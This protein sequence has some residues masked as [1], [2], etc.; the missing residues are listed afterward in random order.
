MLDDDI[1]GG[2]PDRASRALF[3]HSGARP[4]RAPPSRELA[5]AIASS[6]KVH[7]SSRADRLG[8]GGDHLPFYNPLPAGALHTFTEPL[9]NVRASAPASSAF[10]TF[11][12][13]IGPI[14]PP[15]FSVRWRGERR[16]R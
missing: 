3:L 1:F 11:E 8:L 9:D 15:V 4:R 16:G 10:M 2:R 7:S 5:R 13:G 14:L 12:Y 6:S